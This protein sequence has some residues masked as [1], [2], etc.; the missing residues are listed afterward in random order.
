MSTA[1]PN[2]EVGGFRIN[3]SL[4]KNFQASDIKLIIG[5]GYYKKIDSNWFA[6]FDVGATPNEHSKIKWFFQYKISDEN[7]DPFKE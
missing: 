6:G 1:D 7:K 4:L 2:F 3:D 5:W